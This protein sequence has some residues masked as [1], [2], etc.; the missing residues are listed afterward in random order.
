MSVASSEAGGIEP[1]SSGPI[2]EEAV[3]Q[4]QTFLKQWLQLTD[5]INV[6]NAEIRQRRTKAAVLR[7]TI[8]RIM[9]SHNVSTL[10]S[11]KGTI[12]H[13]AREVK[14]SLSRKLL[15]DAC[16]SFFEGDETKAEQLLNFI[17]SQRATTVRHDLKL[18]K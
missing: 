4:L 7:E 16:K 5:E 12:M 17:E 10:N 15:L 8:M 9:S 1:T 2:T 13:R 18:Q 6:L 11:S 3:G 14:Q